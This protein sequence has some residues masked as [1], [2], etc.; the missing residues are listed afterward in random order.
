MGRV[1]DLTIYP[2]TKTSLTSHK[3]MDLGYIFVGIAHQQS[4]A[5]I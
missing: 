1:Y 5:T 3:D 2:R 4:R